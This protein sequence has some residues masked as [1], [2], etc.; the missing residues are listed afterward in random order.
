M[1]GKLRLSY[2]GHGSE[3]TNVSWSPDGG[4]IASA[5]DGGVVDLW[6]ATTGKQVWLLYL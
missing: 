2:R 4:Y 1:T 6:Q 3:V 5:S